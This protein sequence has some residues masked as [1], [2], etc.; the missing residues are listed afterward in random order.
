[1][2]GICA[3]RLY[4]RNAPDEEPRVIEDV[5]EIRKFLSD[6]QLRILKPQYIYLPRVDEGEIVLWDNY[7]LFHSA[8]DYPLEVYGPRTMHQANIGA[9]VGPKGPVPIPAM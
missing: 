8:V 6:I 7:A 3:R 5:Q 4:I 1:M 2:H 9:S